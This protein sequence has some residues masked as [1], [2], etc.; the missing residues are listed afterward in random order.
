VPDH[1][2]RVANLLAKAEDPAIPVPEKQ[3][4]IAKAMHLMEKYDIKEHE[5]RAAR[6]ES[7][8]EPVVEHFSISGAGGHGVARATALGIVAEAMGALGSYIGGTRT[9]T[10]DLRI[11]AYPSTIENIRVVA[12]AMQ[13]VM[14]KLGAEACRG[15][16]G[17]DRCI[18]FRSYLK[19]FGAGVAMHFSQMQSEPELEPDDPSEEKTALILRDRA[20]I[21]LDAFNTFFPEARA[22]RTTK[23]NADTWYRGRAAGYTYGS[24]NVESARSPKSIG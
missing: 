7:Q 16:Q 13:P 8:E 11:V 10:V 15:M 9:R 17:Y 2:T 1:K 23:Q 4:L 20:Q 14:E 6:G 3:A 22:E 24:P 21:V 19:G 12:A 5:A 18:A